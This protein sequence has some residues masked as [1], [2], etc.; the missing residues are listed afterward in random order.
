MVLEYKIK[1]VVEVLQPALKGLHPFHCSL[2]LLRYVLNSVGIMSASNFPLKPIDRVQVHISLLAVAIVAISPMLARFSNRKIPAA[3]AD[4]PL[5]S[6]HDGMSECVSPRVAYRE[7]AKT[8]GP[9]QVAQAQVGPAQVGPAQVGPAQVGP[10]QVGPAQV[11]AVAN[12][13]ND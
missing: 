3:C 9:A 12:G 5:T 2:L 6:A 7:E 11:P 13:N 1:I 4:A 8:D 10:T